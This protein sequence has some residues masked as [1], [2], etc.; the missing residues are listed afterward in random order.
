ME[1]KLEFVSS[2]NLKQEI[3]VRFE[4]EAVY[5]KCSHCK[6]QFEVR[7]PGLGPPDSGILLVICSG[8]LE[9]ATAHIGNVVGFRSVE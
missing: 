3:A 8:I 2:A 1:A 4:L 9:H 7:W 5:C 6:G